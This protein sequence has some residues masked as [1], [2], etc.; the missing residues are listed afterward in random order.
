MVFSSAISPKKKNKEKW[1]YYFTISDT[2]WFRVINML[3]NI[4]MAIRV[5]HYHTNRAVIFFWKNLL[6]IPL[7]GALCTTYPRTYSRWHSICL[8]WV[9]WQPRIR[10]VHLHFARSL[11]KLII[12]RAR[13]THSQSHNFRQIYFF[14]YKPA[15]KKNI[16]FVNRCLF[17]CLFYCCVC[18][19]FALHL[20]L[21]LLI[22][23]RVEFAYIVVP[24]VRAFIGPIQYYL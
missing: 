16:T 3:V 5:C 12:D 2:I 19:F 18:C 20:I 4:K 23:A 21:A 7:A 24:D 1:A 17:F 6:A 14:Y 13:N 15:Q 8:R 10:F 11:V 22:F 9:V